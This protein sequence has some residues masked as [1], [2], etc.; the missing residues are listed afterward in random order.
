MKKFVIKLSFLLFFTFSANSEP[1]KIPLHNWTSQQVGATLM[2]MLFQMVG[3]EIEFISIN[4]LDVYD[5]LCDNEIDIVHEIWEGAFGPAFQSQLDKDCA[6][7][8]GNHDI[9]V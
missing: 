2:G 4:S 5:S 6:I 8:I 3:E 7:E 1:I 9:N